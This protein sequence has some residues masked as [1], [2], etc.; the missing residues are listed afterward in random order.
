MKLINKDKI[1][2]AIFG[3]VIGTVLILCAGIWFLGLP[4]VGN[5]QLS[6]PEMPVS[7]RIDFDWKIQKL[8]GTE[9][10]MSHQF[11]DQ[12]V[13]LNIWATWCGPCVQE[14]PSI[15]KLYQRYKGR[16][17]FVCVSMD[18]IEKIERFRKNKGYTFPLYHIK[19]DAPKELTSFG[20]PATYI[21]SKERKVIIKHIGAAD[22][23]HTSVIDLLDSLFDEK[24]EQ[25]ATTQ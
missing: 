16:V 13:F 3:F 14:M 7:Q 12:I 18:E 9:I 10:L 11:K 15:E 25:V 2:G 19:E 21:I 5:H 20:I 22:W 6:P 17:A 23:Y 4:M 8:D 1:V 24:A